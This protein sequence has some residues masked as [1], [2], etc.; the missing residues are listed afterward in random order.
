MSSLDR[1]ISF[2]TF[3][4]HFLHPSETIFLMS[5]VEIQFIFSLKT[6]SIWRHHFL[7]E[8]LTKKARFKKRVLKI[9]FLSMDHGTYFHLSQPD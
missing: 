5:A 7:H 3:F 4:C 8:Y 1:K 6:W 9:F 2:L